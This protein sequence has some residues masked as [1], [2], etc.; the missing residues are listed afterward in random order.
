MNQHADQHA[1]SSMQPPAGRPLSQLALW[2][3]I[4]GVLSLCVGPLGVVAI[5]LGIMGITRTSKPDGPG[6]MGLAIAGTAVG[7][8]GL[9]GTCLVLGIVLPAIGKARQAA[10]TVIS[11]AQL[12]QIQTGMINFN[13]DRGSLPPADD[14]Q[15]VLSDYLLGTPDDPI[16][17]SPLSDGDAVEYVFVGANDY[18]FDGR[19]IMLYEDPDHRTHDG[20]V[21]VSY[22]DGRVERVDVQVLSAELAARGQTLQR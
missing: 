17:D 16:F 1:D 13:R 12:R 22:D 10:A 15:A 7:V 21:I 8:V 6:G 2:A 18:A 4:V 14:W 3:L 19:R 5:V 9:L 11:E 20:L